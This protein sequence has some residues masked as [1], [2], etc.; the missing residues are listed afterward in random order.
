MTRQRVQLWL[1]VFCIGLL[2]ITSLS[3][4]AQEQPEP[5]DDS[6]VVTGARRIAYVAPGTDGTTTDIY[7]VT[8]PD[9]GQL[10]DEAGWIDHDN[11]PT[12]PR[13]AEDL[14]YE[15]NNLT[16]TAGANE[17]DPQFSVDGT[18]I[19]YRGEADPATY[20]DVHSLF[21][22][23]AD[24]QDTVQITPNGVNVLY[25]TFNP[26]GTQVA[27]NAQ[28]GSSEFK[29]YRSGLDGTDQVTLTPG[30]G[31]NAAFPLWR[32][33]E[34]DEEEIA[35]LRAEGGTTQVVAANPLTAETLWFTDHLTLQQWILQPL[36]GR[37]A[38]FIQREDSDSDWE[39]A[40]INLDTREVT[41]LTDNTTN[42]CCAGLAADGVVQ[43]DMSPAGSAPAYYL[44]DTEDGGRDIYSV[45]LDGSDPV[46]LT[47]D[48]ER[49]YTSALP[50]SSELLLTGYIDHES[51]EPTPRL[52]FSWNVAAR[53]LTGD[54][55]FHTLT[56]GS[57]P[58]VVDPISL[59]Q[60]EGLEAAGLL[61]AV[62][63]MQTVSP[64][65]EIYSQPSKDAE[66]VRTLIGDLDFVEVNAYLPAT[67]SR[68]EGW[69]RLTDGTWV[70][71]SHVRKPDNCP[72]LP[73]ISPYL[74]ANL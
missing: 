23:G 66:P 33:N 58:D 13:V 16:N 1:L 26:N 6:I 21:V 32:V 22:T 7:M 60:L 52:G 25:A 70:P 63:E 53:D 61:S 20:P 51:D 12:T 68:P 48:D 34:N 42:D 35:Y 45:N 55:G 14:R 54:Y 69:Y 67:P 71:E 31:F 44:S 37:Y 18:H 28:W 73:T 57:D 47:A 46:N 29:I 24:G 62:C 64:G 19:A 74:S 50:L 30:E 56:E 27:F 36:F 59:E 15:I 43:T 39:I 3:V 9:A 49:E 11:D 8:L 10:L 38:T 5:E 2:G 65:A 40:T 17:I 41:Q 72:L 4:S